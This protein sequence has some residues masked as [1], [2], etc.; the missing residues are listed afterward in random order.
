MSTPY[1]GEI[2]MFA[3]NF[4]PVGWLLCQGQVLPIAQYDTL[5]TLIGTTYGGDGQATFA[6]PDLAS[7]IPYHQGPGSVI[8]QIGGV[9]QLTLTPDQLP[10]HTHA[11]NASTANA[12]QP[13]PEGNVWG[14]GTLS[15]YA[16]TQTANLTM[17]PSALKPAGG[18]QPHENMPP[19]L[20]LNFIIATEGIYPTPS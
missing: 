6:V 3:G 12:D 10:A 14:S 11:A 18:N 2:R 4:A 13:A 1:I 9:E 8:G 16:S 20:C 15:A 7:R 17:N 5:F 19:F